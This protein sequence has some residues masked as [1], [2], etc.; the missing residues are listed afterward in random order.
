MCGL[1][2]HSNVEAFSF[3]GYNTVPIDKINIIEDLNL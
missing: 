3:L 2:Y 1:N